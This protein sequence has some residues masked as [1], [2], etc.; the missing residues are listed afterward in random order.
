MS[1]TQEAGT[2][3]SIAG[4]GPLEVKPAEQAAG[5]NPALEV[6][7]AELCLPVE[8]LLVSSSRPVPPR[9]MA[10]ALGLVDPEEPT[11]EQPAA[12]AA[13]E[14]AQQPKP[15]RTRRKRAT[16]EFAPE[17]VIKRAVELLNGV[18]K[19]SGRSFRIELV[20]GGYRVMTLPDYG[21]AIAV[22]QGVASAAKLSRPAIETLA[23]IAYRQPATRAQLEAIRGVAC[24]EVLK[25]LLD[26][27]LITIAG[28]AEELGRPLLYATTKQFL[29]A[30]GLSSVKDL[31]SAAELGL[32][33]A[34]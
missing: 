25:T 30:F 10:E 11:P 16:D 21:K 34:G 7:A 33:A 18:Y 13:A 12:E 26:R 20:A 1:T 28:R 2:L 4:N 32:K 31:P 24:G 17:D 22:L 3:A 8:A 9:R 5:P 14:G 19:H 27:K 23:I 29:A 15:K 6:K